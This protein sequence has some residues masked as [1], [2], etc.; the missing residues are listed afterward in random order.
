MEH[1]KTIAF[2]TYPG[3]YVV[4]RLLLDQREIRYFFANETMIGVLPFH[5]N[6]VG[7]IQLKVHPEDIVEA[8]NLLQDW[9][10]N[11]HLRLV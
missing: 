4:F 3:D 10:D 9:N 8:T 11:S 6:A 1:Y 5:S 7:G 2:F